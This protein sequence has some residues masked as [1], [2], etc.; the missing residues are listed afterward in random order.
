MKASFG[1]W[2]GEGMGSLNITNISANPENVVRLYPI[3]NISSVKIYRRRALVN[4]LINYA[5]IF[6]F[7]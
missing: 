3:R 7:H 2:A 1:T 6:Q 4:F 5:N